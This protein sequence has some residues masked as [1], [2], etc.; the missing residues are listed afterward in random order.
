MAIVPT[1]KA[2]LH[3]I[4]H[5]L[6][7]QPLVFQRILEYVQVLY[8]PL[9]PLNLWLEWEVLPARSALLHW[10]FGAVSHKCSFLRVA[11]GYSRRLLFMG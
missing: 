3:R 10:Q 9:I 11:P 6:G 7:Q 2:K 4:L 5:H 1:P 8:R